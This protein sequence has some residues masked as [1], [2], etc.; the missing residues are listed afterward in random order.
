MHQLTHLGS[1]L[2]YP[3]QYT[4]VEKWSNKPNVFSDDLDLKYDFRDELIK[5]GVDL[6]K[7]LAE[8]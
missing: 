2:K 4:Q 5:T 6:F 1:A 3:K 8:L 7:G